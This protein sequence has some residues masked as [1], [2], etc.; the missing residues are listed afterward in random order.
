MNKLF[1][2]AG[3]SAALLLGSVQA[4]SLNPGRGSEKVSVGALSIVAA[5]VASIGGSDR[6]PSLGPVLAITGSGYVIVGL[7]EAGSDLAQVT[8]ESVQG[9]AKLMLDMSKSALRASGAAVG[10]SVQVT[11]VASGTLLVTSGK[12]LAFV[13]N[14]LGESLLEHSRVPS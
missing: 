3:I 2:V 9:G 5:P 1:A 12:V 7:A 14:Q 4:E 10:A 6:G 11:A 13:P 8:L